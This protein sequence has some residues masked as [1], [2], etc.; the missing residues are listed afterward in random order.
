MSNTDGTEQPTLPSD[1][2]RALV[3]KLVMFWLKDMD[4][5]DKRTPSLMEVGRKLLSDNSVTIASV[6][7]GDFGKVAQEAAEQF[8]FDDRG[9]P[10]GAPMVS[11]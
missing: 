7:R 4:N 9:N 2:N 5:D 3:E 11:N 10:V 1:L 8:P 6:R